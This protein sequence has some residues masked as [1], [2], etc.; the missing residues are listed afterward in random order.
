MCLL[1]VNYSVHVYNTS[2]LPNLASYLL[3][4]F[5]LQLRMTRVCWACLWCRRYVVKDF[6]FLFPLSSDSCVCLDLSSLLYITILKTQ[7]GNGTTTCISRSNELTTLRADSTALDS[8]HT[9]ASPVSIATAI[10]NIYSIQLHSS[11]SITSH[12]F[13]PPLFLSLSLVSFSSHLLASFAGGN[14]LAL[15]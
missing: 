8:L 14:G 7:H 5:S 3:F 11:W 15:R 10:A 9:H 13:I 12:H 2:W 6:Y 1:P 4:P